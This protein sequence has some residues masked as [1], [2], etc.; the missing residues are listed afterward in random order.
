ME[1][2]GGF[3]REREEQVQMHEGVELHSKLAEE[4]VCRSGKDVRAGGWEWAMNPRRLD[5]RSEY[6]GPYGLSFVGDFTLRVLGS[7]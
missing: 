3:L 6:K 5:Q 7:Y 1:N 2:E 4:F